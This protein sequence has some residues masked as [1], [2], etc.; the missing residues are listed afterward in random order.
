MRQLSSGLRDLLL[1]SPM[2]FHLSGQYV[3]SL[4][5]SNTDE[6]RND[7]WLKLQKTR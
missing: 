7:L 5:H 3:A 4:T 2:Q 6:E 1:L